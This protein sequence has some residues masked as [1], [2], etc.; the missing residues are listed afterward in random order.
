M[1]LGFR[2]EY[3][4]FYRG[5]NSQTSAFEPATNTGF[6]T[7]AKGLVIVPTNG[8]GGLLDPTAQP[9]TSQLI[10]LFSERIEGTAAL[11]LPESIRKTGPGLY[12]P[13][14]GL[15]WRPGGNNRTVV[16]A[17]YGI[18]PVFLDTNMSLQW[19]H[20]PPLM[21]Q[22]SITNPAASPTFVNSAAT[23]EFYW[24]NPFQWVG[25]SL[26]ASNP[27]PR[28]ALHRIQLAW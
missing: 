17:A 26:V 19:A 2:W 27:N 10:P 4:P 8:S 12:V 9:E 20:V 28:H 22:Q 15:A 3:D 25:S 13:R 5:V 6:D 21:I 1:N 11:H 18:F 16:R 7:S 24:S 14:V 23:G